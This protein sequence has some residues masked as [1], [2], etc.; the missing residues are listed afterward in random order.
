MRR[1]LLVLGA[2]AL[3][4][5]VVIG[6]AQAGGKEEPKETARFDLDGDQGD[7]SEHEEKA[8]HADLRVAETVCGAGGQRTAP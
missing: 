1:L 3:V 8:A 4:A 2:V 7:G 6:L 5:V